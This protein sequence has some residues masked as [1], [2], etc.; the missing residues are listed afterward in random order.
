VRFITTPI[1][2][3]A[4]YVMGALLVSSPYLF[5]FATG[6]PEQWLPIVLGLA[7]LLQTVMTRYE[8][9]LVPVISI[10]VH[11]GLDSANGL[12]LAASPWLLGFAHQVCWPHVLLGLI[13]IG[14]AGCTE[15]KMAVRSLAPASL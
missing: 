14:T 5:G 7:V 12:L 6:G 13:E 15:T 11:L 2:G 1:H 8:L 10:P 3:V 4:D 9:G